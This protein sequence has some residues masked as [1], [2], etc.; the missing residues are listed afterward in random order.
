M[1][2][3]LRVAGGLMASLG[4]LTFASGVLCLLAGRDD[5]VLLVVLGTAT[6]FGGL[7]LLGVS[8]ITAQLAE[9]A[10]MLRT[11]RPDARQRVD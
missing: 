6:A 7:L 2:K 1:L 3:L 11:E 10:A 8:A 4:L 5:L 9:I